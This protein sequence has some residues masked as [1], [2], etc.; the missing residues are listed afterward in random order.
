MLPAPTSK[1]KLMKMQGEMDGGAD[2]GA[3]YV[4]GEKGEEKAMDVR[5]SKEVDDGDVYM[6]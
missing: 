6:Y 4:G 2:G 5:W 1:L 3:G